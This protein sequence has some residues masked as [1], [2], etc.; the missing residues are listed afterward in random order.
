MFT[1]NRDAISI[2]IVSA[3]LFFARTDLIV[4]PAVMFFYVKDKIKFGLIAGIPIITYLTYNYYNFDSIMPISGRVK[5]WYS[6]KYNFADGNG[7]DDLFSKVFNVSFN[8]WVILFLFILMAGLIKLKEL[9][10]ASLII[11]AHLILLYGY[12]GVVDNYHAYYFI[13]ELI[14]LFICLIKLYQ[15]CYSALFCGSIKLTK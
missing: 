5:M 14:Y 2:A 8:G 12:Y 7:F 13:P 4:V 15:S 10:P 1:R 11:V 9:R 6:A 3:L